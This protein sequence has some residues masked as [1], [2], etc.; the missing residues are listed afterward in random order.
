MKPLMSSMGVYSMTE[1][2]LAELR[3]IKANIKEKLKGKKF[4]T[5]ATKDKDALLEALAKMMGLL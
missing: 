3:A 4:G 1:E 2:R 5:L